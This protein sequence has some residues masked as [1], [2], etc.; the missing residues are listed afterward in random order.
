MSSL[1]DQAGFCTV[2]I[3]GTPQVT[4]RFL[5]CW[6]LFENKLLCQKIDA[7]TWNAL[8]NDEVWEAHLSPRK[9]G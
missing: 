7:D 2:F 5:F 1:K 8:K 9:N 3:Y 6:L 4:L